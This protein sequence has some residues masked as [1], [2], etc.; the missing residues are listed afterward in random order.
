MKVKQATMVALRWSRRCLRA[1]RS[2]SP[3]AA[4]GLTAAIVLGGAGVASAANGG[5][6]ILGHSNTETLKSTLSNSNGTPLQLNASTGNPPLKVNN[7][8]QVPSLNASEVGG[9]TA[10]QLS[11]GGDGFTNPGTNTPLTSSFT[12]VA[13]TGAL[14]AGTYYATATALM[15]V[16]SGNVFGF[17]ILTK[18]STGAAIAWGGGDQPGSGYMTAAETAAVQVNA[19]DSLQERCESANTG[20][21][22]FNAGITA[23]RILSSSGTA[24]ASATHSKGAPPQGVK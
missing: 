15:D 20:S 16:P 8:V 3:L 1:V 24:G 17:C 21:S 2:L 14:A 22:A 7:S 23:V 19:G 9:Q 11:T 18:A 13:S 10:S 12:T 4:F 5:N 6:F